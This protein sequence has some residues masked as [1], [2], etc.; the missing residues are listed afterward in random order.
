MEGL[1]S[2]DSAE[3]GSEALTCVFV[4]HSPKGSSQKGPE[5][6]FSVCHPKRG[7]GCFGSPEDCKAVASF[8]FHIDLSNVAQEIVLKPPRSSAKD[9]DVMVIQLTPPT[10]RYS[11]RGYGRL[12]SQHFGVGTSLFHRRSLPRVFDAIAL[13]RRFHLPTLW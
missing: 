3:H 6:F 11:M 10:P 5:L 2:D 12:P 8:R 9:T 13:A 1:V 7:S 4:L